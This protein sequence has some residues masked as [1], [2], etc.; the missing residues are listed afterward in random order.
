MS[1]VVDGSPVVYGETISRTGSMIVRC[2]ADYILKQDDAVWSP[3]G[4][5]DGADQYVLS[6]SGHIDIQVD[7]RTVFMFDVSLED[8]FSL[9]YT[10]ARFLS[11]D[12]VHETTPYIYG[13]VQASF[14]NDERDGIDVFVYPVDM[15]E[16][17]GLVATSNQGTVSSRRESSWV[18]IY[19]RNIDPNQFL[20]VFL[21]NVLVAFISPV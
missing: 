20:Q 14:P 4:R 6:S 15:G 10:Y 18:S 17:S 9:R 1:V 2:D 16:V 13:Y 11:G 21:G 7:G 3:I 5:I 19:V 12:V 8:D